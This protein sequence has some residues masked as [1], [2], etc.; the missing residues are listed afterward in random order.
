[1][2]KLRLLKMKKMVAKEQQ[3][4]RDKIGEHFHGEQATCIVALTLS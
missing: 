1:M 4:Q 2:S 3:Q